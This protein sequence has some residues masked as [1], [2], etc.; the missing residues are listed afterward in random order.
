MK[1]IRNSEFYVN[2]NNKNENTNNLQNYNLFIKKTPSIQ[3][4]KN[5]INLSELDN[6]NKGNINKEKSISPQKNSNE[7]SHEILYNLNMKKNL[8]FTEN[9]D[10]YNKINFQNISNS[11]INSKLMNNKEIL[12][13]EINNF[14]ID[15]KEE[16]DG[17]K[18]YKKSSK[19]IDNICISKV[20]VDKIEYDYPRGKRL[21]HVSSIID[22]TKSLIFRKEKTNYYYIH[23]FRKHL[24]S[25]EHL[26][27]SHITLVLLEKKYKISNDETTNF[28]ECYDKL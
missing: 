11:S 9:L 23:L 26:L 2:S 8:D 25:E 5:E 6:F 24:L 3:S 20:S 21:R 14:D 15:N 1:K 13:P 10:S 19:N 27:K 7:N 16:Y 17:K 28:F 22:L 18:R 4:N 12:K